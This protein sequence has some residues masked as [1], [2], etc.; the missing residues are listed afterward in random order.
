MS[1]LLTW[2]DGARIVVAYNG[3]DF[4]MRRGN[5]LLCFKESATRPGHGRTRDGDPYRPMQRH[6]ILDESS[7][8]QN[9]AP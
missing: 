6:A 7:K 3:A 2:M 8:K 9:H 5:I 4:D 1:D